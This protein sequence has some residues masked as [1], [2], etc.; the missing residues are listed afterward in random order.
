MTTRTRKAAFAALIALMIAGA[1]FVSS[2]WER[3][4]KLTDITVA[5]SRDPLSAPVYVAEDKGFFEEEGLRVTLQPH[6]TGMDATDSVIGGAAGFGTAA[7]IPVMFAGLSGRPLFVVATIASSSSHVRI[8]ARRDRGIIRPSDLRG[9]TVGVRFHTSSEYF[10]SAFLTYNLMNESDVRL[11]DMP[12]D[13]MA[14]ALVRGEIDAAASWKPSTALQQKALGKEAVVFSNRYVYDLEWN[15]VG[16][17]RFVRENPEAVEGLL[18]ALVRAEGF[19]GE[20]TLEA[21][22]ITARRLGLRDVSFAGI[23]FE[24]HLEQSLLA[25]LETQARWAIRRGR[26]KRG[27]VPDYLPMLYTKPLEKVRPEAVTVIR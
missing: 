20:N 3:A 7:D 11:V 9:K 21:R 10:L 6:A 12:P 2:R 8:V 16:S 17:P 13:R 5:V 19:I 1:A 18:R 24:V 27:E 15:V 23:S 4:G 14:N 25:C 22:E 26:T